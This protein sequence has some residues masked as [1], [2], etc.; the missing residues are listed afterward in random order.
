MPDAPAGAAADPPAPGE[1]LDLA[2]AAATAAGQLLLDGLDQA[3][4]TVDTK[5][6]PTDMVTEMDRAAEALIADTIHRS[7]PDDALL[8][9][10]GGRRA[11]RAGSP[12][13]WIVDPLDG[14]TNYLYGIPAFAVSIA[15]EVN[16]ALTAAAVLDV[17]HHELFAASRGGGARLNGAPL[18]IAGPPTLATALL[19]TGFSYQPAVRAEQAAVLRTVLP[20]VRDIRR[21]GSAA[22]DL[23]SVACGRLDAYYEFGL[24]PSDASRGTLVAS[25]AGAVVTTLTG[26]DSIEDTVVAA[27]RQLA[28]PLCRLL[29]E[30][31]AGQVTIPASTSSAGP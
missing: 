17:V 21:G 19:G 15:A 3:R 13:R 10:E 26:R 20:S 7:R 16:G 12:V 4:L 25:E 18:A 23:C 1:L 22:L 28:D 14:T 11:G 2:V 24:Q 8:G 29:L 5:S 31:G 6:S 30:A 9:E 27:P